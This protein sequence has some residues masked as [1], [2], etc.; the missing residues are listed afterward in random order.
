MENYAIRS[1]KELEDKILN[2]PEKFAV[3]SEKQWQVD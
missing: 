3:L 2:G 1:S